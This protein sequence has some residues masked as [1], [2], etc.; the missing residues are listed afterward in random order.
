MASLAKSTT[1]L[2]A[3]RLNPMVSSAALAAA[4][5][6]AGSHALAADIDGVRAPGNPGSFGDGAN[7]AGGVVPGTGDNGYINNGGIATAAAAVNATFNDLR[8]GFNP[9]SS[10]SL[11]ISGG[12]INAQGN[13]AFGSNTTGTG[14]FNISSG[15]LNVGG[16][17]VGDFSIGDDGEGTATISGGTITT[18]FAYIGKSTHGHGHV[19]QTGGNF[20]V[21]RNLVMDELKPADT[22][23]VQNPSDYTMSGGALSVGSEMYIGAHG[24]CTF[25]LSG[26]GSISVVGTI[27]IAASGG[28]SD[29]P[30]GKGTLNMSGGTINVNGPSAYFVVADHGDGTFNFSAGSLT[31]KYYNIGQNFEPGFSSRGLVNQTGGSA[32]AEFAWVIGEESR[33]ANLYDLS[34]GTVTVNGAGIEEL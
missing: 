24:P 29:P 12:T 5:M 32:T 7:W 31:T 26:T 22:S 13:A 34:G 9:A 8:I 33:S 19:T 2:R 14:T 27:H 25:N 4:G 21:Q 16:G 10:G 28:F 6:F 17:T 11:S 3:V 23:A 18:R 30:G 1:G 20:T 15:A